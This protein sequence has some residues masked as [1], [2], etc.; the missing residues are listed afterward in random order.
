MPL[1]L[2]PKVVFLLF[3][4]CL[5]T[6]ED[7]R[8]RRIPNTITLN[9]IWAALIIN[10]FFFGGFS[11][12]GLSVSGFLVSL[13]I[14]LIPFMLGGL[15][16]GDLK[17]FMMVGAFM[18]AWFALQTF[19]YASVA[20]GVLALCYMGWLKI[21]QKDGSIHFFKTLK[22][23]WQHV[24][25]KTTLEVNDHSKKFPYSLAITAGVLFALWVT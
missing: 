10:F 1:L 20:G 7:L 8:T 17:L 16:G 23:T 15:G 6:G 25:Y 13:G 21:T 12:L 11:G 18:G 3:L 14:G 2:S 5:A 22:T 9:G 24:A 4:L 19:L